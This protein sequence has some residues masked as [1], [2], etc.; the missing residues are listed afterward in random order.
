MSHLRRF[1]WVLMDDIGWPILEVGLMGLI[2]FLV[3]ILP[4][5]ALGWLACWAMGREYNTTTSVI[6]VPLFLALILLV[7]GCLYVRRRWIETRIRQPE[8]KQP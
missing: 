5:I 6:G 1:L 2:V 8:E 4:T 3:F 7:C